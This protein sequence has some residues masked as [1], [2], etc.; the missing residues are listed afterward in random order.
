L[1]QLKI[2]TDKA[3]DW[4]DVANRRK[5]I[6]S[7][8]KPANPALAIAAFGTPAWHHRRDKRAIIPFSPNLGSAGEMA[9]V[10][11]V[12]DFTPG[13]GCL[14]SDLPTFDVVAFIQ[15]QIIGA[16]PP[17]AA[18]HNLLAADHNLREN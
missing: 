5:I 7:N 4:S 17:I 16:L 10:G 2:W 14:M 12:D 3:I 13:Q 18:D 1:A 15:K 11:T 9:Q 6:T 8:G